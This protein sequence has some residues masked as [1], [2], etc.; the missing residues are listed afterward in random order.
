MFAPPVLRDW[1]MAGRPQ[2]HPLFGALKRR[3]EQQSASAAKADKP[4]ASVRRR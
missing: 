2:A 4:P 3:I 1:I